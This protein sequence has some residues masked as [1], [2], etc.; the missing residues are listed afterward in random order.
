MKYKILSTLVAAFAVSV[1]QAQTHNVP[2]KLVINLTI[3]QLRTDYLE[4][5]A[6]LFGDKGFKRLWKEGQVYTQVNMPFARPDRSSATA[7]IY[8]GA[9]PRLNGVI[10]NYWL[11]RKTLNVFHCADDKS[12]MGVYTD[13]NTS[14]QQ[15]SVSTFADELKIA[16]QGKAI[17]YAI[18]PERDAAVIAAGHAAN[19]AF[20]INDENAKWAGTTYYDDFPYWLTNFNDQ[21][22]IDYRIDDMEWQPVYPSA[23]YKYLQS[24]WETSGFDYKF[25][26]INQRKVQ[27]FKTTPIVNDEVN[28]I[29]Q[30]CLYSGV[31]GTDPITDLLSV[32]YY[33]GNYDHKTTQEAPIEMQD[34]YVRL[35]RS[36]G[37]LLDMIDQRVGLQNAVIV[38]SSTG[39]V[40]A[41]SFDLNKYRIPRGEFHV[42]RCAALLN[43]YL[44]ALY[45]EGQYVER[46]FGQQIYFN[47]K[48]LEDKQLKLSDIQTQSANFLIEFNGVEEVYT[49]HRLLLGT[50]SP[51]IEKERNAYNGER[52]GDLYVKV[53]PGWTVYQ[54]KPLK[55][56]LE[57]RSY[58]ASPLFFL[59][60]NITPKVK[61]VT[62]SAERIAPTVCD[63]MRIRPP[64]ACSTQPLQL[65]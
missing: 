7:V 8:T 10:A 58:I 43:M 20:W 65:Y 52:S 35:D 62:V 17:I 44:M 22:G 47:H 64:N 1:G 9:T 16:T 49:S 40:D 13:Q 60:K 21:E 30:K 46:H 32:S 23:M 12:Y 29:V 25:K 45:G 57:R 2:P 5:F 50:W 36:L 55:N 54:D 4:D 18:A 48:L 6:P 61:T 19:G 39:Y 3:D 24:D 38:V 53:L 27:R 63:I 31:I 51:E 37:Q 14:A 41:G 11:D 59:G 34:M 26:R 56:K 33:A 42:N 28:K 15:I